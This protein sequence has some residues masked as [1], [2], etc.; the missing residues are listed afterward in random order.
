MLID[1]RK[2]LKDFRMNVLQIGVRKFADFLGILPSQLLAI[3]QGKPIKKVS[4]SGFVR[5]FRSTLNA[6]YDIDADIKY[7]GLKACNLI[8]ELNDKK[9]KK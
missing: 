6:V 8:D 1:N 9:P 3:E 2:A 5:T 4:S 7:M